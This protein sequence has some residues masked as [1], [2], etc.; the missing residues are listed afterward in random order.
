MRE[1]GR[2][3]PLGRKR[4]ALV[5]IENGPFEG[6]D[7]LPLSPR[8]IIGGT[9]AVRL[10]LNGGRRTL[11]HCPQPGIWIRAKAYDMRGCCLGQPGFKPGFPM[12]RWRSASDDEPGAGSDDVASRI[13]EMFRCAIRATASGKQRDMHWTAKSGLSQ[14]I[15]RW[16]TPG[17]NASGTSVDVEIVRREILFAQW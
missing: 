11:C 7:L 17:Q 4:L 12:A 6:S 10:R 5:V 8:T 2:K 9:V 15:T 14:G 16:R 13:A 3:G 1:Q